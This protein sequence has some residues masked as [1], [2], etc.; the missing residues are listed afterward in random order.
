MSRSPYLP[1]RVENDQLDVAP[2]LYA[3]LVGNDPHAPIEYEGQPLSR[4]QLRADVAAFQQWLRAQG[5]VQGDRVAVML[6]N[7]VQ[8]IALIYALVLS[9]LTWVPINTRLRGAGLRYIFEHAKPR[10][11]VVDDEFEPLVREQPL[12]G[13]AIANLAQIDLSAAGPLEHVPSQGGDMLCLIYTSGTTGAPK[14][15]VFTHRMMRIATE[16]ALL[17]AN[18]R[19]G[20]RAFLWEP[21]CH[22]G[23]AQM[24]LVPFLAKATLLVVDRFSASQFWQ[25]WQDNRATHL[26]YL[27]GV[28]DILMQMPEGSNPL[29]ARISVAW[30][31]GVA[32]SNWQPIRER[33][34]CEL[35]ECYGMTECSSFA[36]L[37][38][39]GKPG[40]IGKALPWI[41][42]QLLD[43]N[44]QPVSV[45][46]AGQIVLESDLEGAFLPGYLDN[47]EATAKALRHGRLYT[48]DMARQDADGDLYFIGRSSD[49]MRVRGENVSAWEVER[50]FAEHPCI[51]ASAAMGVKGAVGEQEIFLYVKFNAGQAVDWSE[52]V[53]WARP[54]LAA[55]QLPRYYAAIE[56]FDLTPS[57][58]IQKHK[59]S[60]DVGQA[61]ARA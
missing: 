26:H 6:N 44:D 58:R 46:A 54:R 38:G 9:G 22:I 33:L 57:Q 28:L 11:A 18:I 56:R 55:F 24:L 40:S 32:A 30:G 15:V 2:L 12:P 31:A 13:V 37:N 14:G 29:G 20:D 25:Q 45:G 17:V 49:S 48:G 36:T 35:R 51:E 39:S 23:G 60:P 53:Q 50:V 7:S 4:A 21:L 47:P 16:A 27:G 41:R 59:L 1:Q 43:E 61:W 3:G 42:L 8:H 34:G 52:L 5:L 19:D 10:L